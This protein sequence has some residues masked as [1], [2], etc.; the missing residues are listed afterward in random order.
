[1]DIKET[2]DLWVLCDRKRL[3]IPDIRETAAE[4][5]R[6]I[7]AEI[8]S[9]GLEV[10]GPWLFI[11]WHL[12]K[13][14]KTLFDW[15]ICRPVKKP[16][17]YS[18]EFELAHLEPIMVASRVHQGSLRTIFTKG[19]APLAA[20]LDVS[21]YIYSGESREIYH[22]WNGPGAPYHKIEIQFGLLR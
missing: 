19:Y 3:R 1:M 11:A 6:K 10:D 17:H 4:C 14:G 2:P 12:P 9:F 22:G 20:E 21:R 8:G 15:A 13:D 18:G 16:E 7:D 5:T